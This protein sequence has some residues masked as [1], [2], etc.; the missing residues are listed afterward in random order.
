MPSKR[1][2]PSGEAQR[3]REDTEPPALEVATLLSASSSSTAG[4]SARRL[5]RRQ[6]S[7]VRPDPIS[8]TNLR[9]FKRATS[10]LSQRGGRAGPRSPHGA[11]SDTRGEP[12]V[13]IVMPERRARSP[14]RS[15]SNRWPPNRPR[16]SAPKLSSHMDASAASA[17]FVELALAYHSTGTGGPA[18]T[19]LKCKLSRRA[20]EGCSSRPQC[21]RGCE[22]DA[23]ASSSG[24]AIASGTS[25]MLT[26]S[27]SSEMLRESH[28]LDFFRPQ[29]LRGCEADTEAS[30]SGTAIAS[31]TSAMLTRSRSSE[32]LREFHQ[33]DFFRATSASGSCPRTPSPAADQDPA[34]RA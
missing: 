13:Q 15:S 2:S 20:E 32:M 10:P 6:R 22:A 9:V 31:G 28:Q 14:V 30:S 23:E 27:R 25:A 21:V 11:A 17:S 34:R 24:T 3:A 8:P 26:R 1:T 18:S 29:C 7:G 19:L 16:G 33:L 12:T 4:P 5:E